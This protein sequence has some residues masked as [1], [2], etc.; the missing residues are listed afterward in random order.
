MSH[1]NYIKIEVTI[2]LEAPFGHDPQGHQKS[3]NIQEAAEV[4]ASIY[5]R[6][7]QP[8]RGERK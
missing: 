5:E 8:K 2:I 7:N 6:R 3:S 1:R 4:T